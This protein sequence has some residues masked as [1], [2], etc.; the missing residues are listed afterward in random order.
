[1]VDDSFGKDP[2]SNTPSCDSFASGSGSASV[3]T[4]YGLRY[5]GMISL[6]CSRHGGGVGAVAA[7]AQNISSSSY[8]VILA[9]E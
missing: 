4:A 3:I 6:C 1:L 8:S 2:I 7:A 5:S 9:A